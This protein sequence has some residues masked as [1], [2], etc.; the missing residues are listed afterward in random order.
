[1]K[2][3]VIVILMYVCVTCFVLLLRFLLQRLIRII[4]TIFEKER[5]SRL[6]EVLKA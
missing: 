2:F 1:M 3:G 4:Q 6:G 5:L